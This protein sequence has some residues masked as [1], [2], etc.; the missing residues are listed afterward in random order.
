MANP[1]LPVW[2]SVGCASGAV[3]IGLGAFGAHALGNLE[4]KLLKTWETAA[5][6][7]L[8]HSVAL[9]VAAY[10]GRSHAATLLAA[11]TGIFSGSLYALVLTGQ[12]KLGAITPVGGLLMIAGWLSLMYPSAQARLAD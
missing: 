8:V 5:H 1:L 7:H 3:A 12:R 11:G 2:W 10:T 6:Y 9:L 4:P